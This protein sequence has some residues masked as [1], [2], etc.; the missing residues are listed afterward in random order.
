M[1]ASLPWLGS[2]DGRIY[3]VLKGFPFN[4][5]NLASAY[6][7]RINRPGRYG[8]RG[9]TGLESLRFLAFNIFILHPSALILHRRFVP[10]AGC[11]PHWPRLAALGGHASASCLRMATGIPAIV[12]RQAMASVTIVSR[13]FHCS[14]TRRPHALPTDNASKPTQS[15][16]NTRYDAVRSTTAQNSA[17][18][19]P[20]S[21]INIIGAA[22]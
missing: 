9:W 19:K 8:Q 18:E 11:D 10:F 17:A 21:H 22:V 14:Q 15:T 7:T 4:E 20:H 12:A 6:R 16:T 3:N 13:F 5:P 2:H 1:R